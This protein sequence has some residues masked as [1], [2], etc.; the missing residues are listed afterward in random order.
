MQRVMIMGQPGSGKSTLARH[1]GQAT[2]LPVFHMDQIHW[3][4]GWIERRQ[5]E[6]VALAQG[7]EARDQWIFEG[8]LSQTYASRAARADVIIWLDFPLGL[9]FWR[10][11]RRTLTGLG[12]NR[13]DLPRDCPERPST[14]TLVFWWYIWTS[15]HSG[16]RRIAHAVAEAPPGTPVFQ[17]QSLAE[18]RQCLDRVSSANDTQ[19]A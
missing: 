6:S 2:G 17:V 15:R 10:V 18:V 8:G 1:L 19:S 11:V 7:V 14:G 13:P 12:R 5:A 16:R 9:R 3:E 4:P